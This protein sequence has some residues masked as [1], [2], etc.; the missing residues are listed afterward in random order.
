MT[1]TDLASA[2]GD[3]TRSN[4]SDFE[5]TI[6]ALSSQWVVD[7]EPTTIAAG[8]VGAGPTSDVLQLL[9]TGVQSFNA[10]ASAA[11]VGMSARL[12]DGVTDLIQ[13]VGRALPWLHHSAER[14]S[15]HVLND[16][17]GRLVGGHRIEFGLP[18]TDVRHEIF[19]VHW[20][21]G[22]STEA[23][24]RQLVG[25]KID[26]VWALRDGWRGPGSLAPSQQARRLYEAAIQVLPVR[27]LADAQPTPTADGGLYM[28]WTRGHR[29]YSAEITSSGR[30]LLNSFVSDDDYE[31]DDSDCDEIIETPT[32][33]DLV[34][35][36]CRGD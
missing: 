33:N 19:L 26:R 23:R 17:F 10:A 8:V 36:L 5:P 13:N 16:S 34:R 1:D 12:T 15:F 24:T 4:A 31:G 18:S 20:V 9:A 7:W 2:S 28:E 11:I 22:G 35:F 32:A 6:G 27:C 14:P 21:E 29:D 30:L 3:A 25:R